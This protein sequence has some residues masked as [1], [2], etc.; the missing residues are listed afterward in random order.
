MH[1]GNRVILDVFVSMKHP[2][3]L[4]KTWDVH[5]WLTDTPCPNA[6]QELQI[7]I[8][9][10]SNNSYDKCTTELGALSFSS[11]YS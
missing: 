10:A 3:L 1:L 11:K 7:I 2:F 8:F 4:N 6:W 5:T 9:A